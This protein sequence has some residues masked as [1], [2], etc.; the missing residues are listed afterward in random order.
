MFIIVKVYAMDFGVKNAILS[1]LDRQMYLDKNQI[2]LV[3]S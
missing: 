3:K 1:S 2:N